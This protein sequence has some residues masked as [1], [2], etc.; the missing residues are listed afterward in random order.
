MFEY[1][2][3]VLGKNI[4]YQGKYVLLIFQVR[5]CFQ[6]CNYNWS[7]QIIGWHQIL[8]THTH[9]YVTSINFLIIIFWLYL[10]A[11][12]HMTNNSISEQLTK[13]STQMI[14]KALWSVVHGA[15]SL[16][17]QWVVWWLD[18]SLT[19]THLVFRVHWHAFTKEVLLKLVSHFRE[20]ICKRLLQSMRKLFPV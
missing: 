8:Y 11:K 6:L 3:H 15:H 17:S 10:L 12:V 1:T 5:Y 14:L 19:V 2:A 7:K 18:E 20:D 9:T 13:W 16:L 4:N